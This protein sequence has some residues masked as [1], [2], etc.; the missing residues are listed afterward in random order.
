MRAPPALHLAPPIALLALAACAH[1]P[2]HRE[3][4]ASA[5][6]A[7]VALDL[8]PRGRMVAPVPPGWTATPGDAQP[9][10]PATLRLDP[11]SGHHLL[12]LT[13]LYDPS[14]A[15]GAPVSE[16][17]ARTMADLARQKALET[18]LELEVPLRPLGGGAAGW[19]FSVTDRELGPGGR[20]PA[21]DEFRALLQGAAAVGG[22]VVAFTLLDDG[23]GPHRAAALAIVRGVRHEPAAP[24]E[25]N[26]A[27]V[28]VSTTAADPQPEPQSQ[29]PSPSRSQPQPQ[30]RQTDPEGWRTQGRAPLSV[31]YPGRPW[32]VALPAEGWRVDG[33]EV[34]DDGR[35]VHL[36]AEDPR[37]GV[38]ISVVLSDARGRSS[39]AACADADWRRIAI[40]L[41]EAPPATRR[42]DG[43]GLRADYF[44]ATQRGRRVDQQNAS[45]WWY[46]D[47]VCV[48]VH[49]SLMGF[50][51]GDAPR[52]DQALSGVAFAEAL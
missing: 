15:P 2:A 6:T 21:P 30:P 42:P 36:V 47:G 26:D 16:G 37:T 20:A 25:A 18:S 31:A 7:R 41:G 13:P 17:S 34:M 22:L 1:A 19:W 28:P 48:H 8:G 43:D 27:V 23:D 10:V 44:V 51:A 52:L 14:V 24:G 49:A 9:P 29:P 38:V 35:L 46:R 45:R 32:S 5:P 12:L 3:P 4:V 33:P 11:P 50:Q 39:A 40:S